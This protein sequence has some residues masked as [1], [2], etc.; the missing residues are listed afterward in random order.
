MF[1]PSSLRRRGA[2]RVLGL[3]ECPRLGE[4]VEEGIDCFGDEPRAGIANQPWEGAHSI[5]GPAGKST[6]GC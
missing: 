4:A 2:F 5:D 1:S 3:P 6:T